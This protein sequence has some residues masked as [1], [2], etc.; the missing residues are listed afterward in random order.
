MAWVGTDSEDHEVPTLRPQAGLP[1]TRS[2]TISDCPGPQ[3]GL[4]H[5]QGWGIHNPSGQPVPA[6]HHSLGEKLPPDI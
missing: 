3:L 6:P 2:S 1:A 5:L 4:E